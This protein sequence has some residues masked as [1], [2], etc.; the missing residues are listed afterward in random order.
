MAEK[1]QL[2]RL[3]IQLTKEQEREIVEMRK[4]DEFCRTSYGELMRRLI[5]EALEMRRQKDA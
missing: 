2:W 5:D 4:T 3:S 1:E